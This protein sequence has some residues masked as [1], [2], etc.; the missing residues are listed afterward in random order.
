MGALE[1][2]TTSVGMCAADDMDACMD[3]TCE[4]WDANEATLEDAM[5]R[6]ETCDWTEESTMSGT[7][8]SVD[9][10]ECDAVSAFESTCSSVE[11]E[12]RTEDMR[13][14]CTSPDFEGYTIGFEFMGLPACFGH[15]CDPEGD[16]GLE[17]LE[18]IVTYEVMADLKDSIEEETGEE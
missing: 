7:T 5:E 17:E 12:F 15:A 6:L 10:A 13:I 18:E 2:D 4:M 8:V 9:F 14:T 3:T 1:G 16:E 11:G